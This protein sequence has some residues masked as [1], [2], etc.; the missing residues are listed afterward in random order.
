MTLAF[1]P[2][3][4]PTSA[5]LA[6]RSSANSLSLEFRTIFCLLVGEPAYFKLAMAEGSTVALQGVVDAVRQRGLQLSGDAQSWHSRKP[7]TSQEPLKVTRIEHHCAV[8]DAKHLVDEAFVG[9]LQVV[10]PDVSVPRWSLSA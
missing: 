2:R 10:R 1:S 3:R 9:E 5:K 6:S 7:Q 4:G 8:G